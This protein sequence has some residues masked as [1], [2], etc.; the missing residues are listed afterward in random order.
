MLGDY[1]TR[2]VFLDFVI[3]DTY[4]LLKLSHSKNAKWARQHIKNN[5]LDSRPQ[6]TQVNR[7]IKLRQRC[8]IQSGFSRNE[9]EKII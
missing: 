8:E 6:Y 3:S 5:T 4:H 2:H 1:F 9:S 7:L